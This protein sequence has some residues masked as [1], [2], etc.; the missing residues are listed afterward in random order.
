MRIP[1]DL[2]VCWR[3]NARICKFPGMHEKKRPEGRKGGFE[4]TVVIVIAVFQPWLNTQL[5]IR[6]PL[7][8]VMAMVA[9]RGRAV[10]TPPAP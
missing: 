7:F 10:V 5:P 4:K 9:E 6:L 1:V 2:I 3:A 8:L